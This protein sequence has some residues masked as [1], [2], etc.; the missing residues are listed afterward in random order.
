MHSNGT[1]FSLLKSKY[2]KYEI[3]LIKFLYKNHQSIEL[4]QTTN[5]ESSFSKKKSTVPE[6]NSKIGSVDISL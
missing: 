5:Q 3:L 6:P 1:F 4:R 2:K